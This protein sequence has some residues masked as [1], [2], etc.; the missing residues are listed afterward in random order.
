MGAEQTE[1]INSNGGE[2]QR[3]KIGALAARC[4]RRLGCAEEKYQPA[5]MDGSE[6]SVRKARRREK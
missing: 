6:K 5:I 3:R 1:E 4:I 2:H